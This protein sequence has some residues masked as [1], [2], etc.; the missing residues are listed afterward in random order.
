MVSRRT[1][2]AIVIFIGILLFLSGIWDFFLRSILG[3]VP[4]IGDLFNLFAPT[5]SQESML[6]ILIGLALIFGGILLA[7][8]GTKN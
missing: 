3:T 6:H 8:T 4:I 1:V 7:R 2:G 5:I